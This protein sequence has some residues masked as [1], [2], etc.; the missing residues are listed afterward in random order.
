VLQR[1]ISTVLRTSGSPANT[2]NALAYPVPG[3]L[4]GTVAIL[5][6]TRNGAG[7]LDEQL[8]SI[9]AQ[10]FA[11]WRVVIS[12]D[13]STDGTRGILQSFAARAENRDRVEL[14]EGAQRGPAP[15][16]LSLATDS[17]IIADY[18][19]YCDQDDVWDRDKLARALRFLSSVPA[20]IPALYC[21]RTTLIDDTGKHIGLSP[22]FQA[23]PSF[24]NALV[25]SVGGGNTMV[26]NKAA[27]GLLIAAGSSTAVSHDWWTYLLVSGAGGCVIY[28]P[29]PSIAY[30]QHGS[31]YIG[32]NRSATALLRRI[33]M[34]MGGG[35]TIW[36]ERNA[37]ALVKC[38]FLLTHENRVVLGRFLDTRRGSLVRRLRALR[39]SGVYRQTTLGQLSLLIAVALN[40]L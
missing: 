15:N 5:L 19:A 4:T 21:S 20:S 38:P 12:D 18:F 10:S 11:G 28:D 29:R 16:F 30:R 34:V 33:G 31:N 14:R 39:Q 1:V 8:N 36:N 13:A 9:A 32:G 37:A 23:A 6:C 27:Q 2:S 22:L 40:R 3:D 17:K 7:F 26:F 25:Q 35:W 24:R